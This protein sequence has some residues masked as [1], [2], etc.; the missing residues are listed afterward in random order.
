MC[1]QGLYPPL[2]IYPEGGTTNGTH[3]V[4]FKKGAFFSLRAVSPVVIM[5]ESP[6]FSYE[7]CVYNFFAQ[8]ILC[9]CLGKVSTTTLQLPNFEPNEYF[10]KHH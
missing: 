9:A 4:K 8:S 6:F 7:N 5:Y 10:F 1:E 2:I 3:L